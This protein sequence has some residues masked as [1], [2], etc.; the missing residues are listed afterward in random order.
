MGWGH[1]IGLESLRS[2]QPG[3]LFIPPANDQIANFEYP[4][5]PGIRQE[6]GSMASA[7]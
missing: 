6:G 2:V 7:M 5:H 1:R 4:D 3:S